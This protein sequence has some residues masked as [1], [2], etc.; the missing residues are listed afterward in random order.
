M[1]LPIGYFVYEVLYRG[2]PPGSPTLASYHIIIGCQIAD[3]FGNVSISYIGP[4]TPTAAAALG[5]TLPATI[6]SLNMEMADQNTV[7]QAQNVALLAQ[8]SSLEARLAIDS[9]ET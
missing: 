7:L 9:P 2:Q 4:I 8:V 6:A 3:A 5:M 1:A